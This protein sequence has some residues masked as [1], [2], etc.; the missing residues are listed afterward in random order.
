MTLTFPKISRQFL[1]IFPKRLDIFL[2][3]FTLS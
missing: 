1:I 2:K 3:M